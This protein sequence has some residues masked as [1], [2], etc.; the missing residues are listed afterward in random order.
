MAAEFL[1]ARLA[2]AVEEAR[3]R[4]NQVIGTGTHGDNVEAAFRAAS[5]VLDRFLAGQASQET[6]EA[7]LIDMFDR[8]GRGTFVRPAPRPPE[9]SPSFLPKAFR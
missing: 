5:I 2:Q 8:V 7:I 1:T 9:D 4:R 6:S 3:G